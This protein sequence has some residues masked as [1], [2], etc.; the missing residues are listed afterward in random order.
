MCAD[1]ITIV[2][3]IMYKMAGEHFN[4]RTTTDSDDCEHSPQLRICSDHSS[5]VTSI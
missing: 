4:Y 3:T 1:N 5:S 2:Y